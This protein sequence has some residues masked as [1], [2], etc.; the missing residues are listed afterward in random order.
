MPETLNYL[1]QES[2]GPTLC[3]KVSSPVT[4]E[5]YV[6]FLERVKVNIKTYGEFRLC[7]LYENFQG[8]DAEA[9]NMD[10]SFYVEYGR[11]LKKFCLINPPEKEVMSKMVTKPMISGELK[12]FSKSKQNEA[13]FWV[14]A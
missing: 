6:D 2:E 14:K 1:M 10:V 11:Y 3:Y 9:A 8:W 13:F 4:V 5:E 12:I 7:L